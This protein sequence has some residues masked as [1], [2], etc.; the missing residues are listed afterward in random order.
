MNILL[1]R[2]NGYNDLTHLSFCILNFPSIIKIQIVIITKE[3][4]VFILTIKNKNTL[5]IQI[6]KNSSLNFFLLIIL[7]HVI[8]YLIV[9]ENCIHLC[10]CLNSKFQSASVDMLAVCR[11]LYILFPSV[12]Y[13]IHA[14]MGKIQTKEG[15]ILR[16]TNIRQWSLGFVVMM[17]WPQN[18]SNLKVII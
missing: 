6:H 16:D 5:E 9:K 1:L 14:Y 11:L 7:V 13:C 3:K 18:M 4:F 15:N 2:L 8:K 17:L 10:V 12:S